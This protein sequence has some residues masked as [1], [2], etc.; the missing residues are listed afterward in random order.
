LILVID[1]DVTYAVTLLAG[2]W[3]GSRRA[4]PLLNSAV[5]DGAPRS[6]FNLMANNRKVQPKL[7]LVRHI[8]I[9]R[10]IAVLNIQ[11]PYCAVSRPNTQSY[12]ECC[13]KLSHH[14]VLGLLIGFHLR[15]KVWL[16]ITGHGQE[17][18][19]RILRVQLSLNVI[20]NKLANV[21]AFS[22]PFKHVNA[23]IRSIKPRYFNPLRYVLRLNE[24]PAIFGFFH[25]FILWILFKLPEAHQELYRYD[26]HHEE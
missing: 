11:L 14:A 19:V 18:G 10:L 17:L 13:K 26:V 16:R 20:Y 3:P 8:E 7:K 24:M 4:K 22:H 23:I 6:R 12:R 25:S 2:R 9:G 1:E 15:F 5:D 21:T